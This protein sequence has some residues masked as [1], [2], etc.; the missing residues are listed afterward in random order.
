MVQRFLL[1][2]LAGMLAFG[3]CHAADAA[4]GDMMKKELGKLGGTWKLVKMEING[5]SLLKKN[6]NTK[7]LIKDGKVFS[8]AQNA[9]KD[10]AQLAKIL[11]PSRKPKTITLPYEGKLTFYGI[12]E[13]KG[14][15]VRVCGD[16]V[17]AAS[18]KNPEGRRPKEFNSTKGL[19]LVFKRVKK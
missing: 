12:Y 7:I 8:E 11:D 1:I 9:P 5:K 10:E 17:D 2:V 15:V 13:V 19:L 14:N 18:E 3:P 6:E 16:A 4:K